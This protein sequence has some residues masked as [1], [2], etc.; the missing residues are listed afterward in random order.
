MSLK[1]I[2]KSALSGDTLILRGRPGPQGQP[3][4]ERVLHL[5]GI[6]APRLGNAER[7]DEAYAFESRDFLR[8]LT[9]GKEVTFVS[10][11]SLPS[12]DGTVRDIGSAS[13]GDLD[14]INEILK[15]GW[16]KVKESKREDNDVDIARKDLEDQARSSGKG[17]WA[18]PNHPPRQVYYTMPPDSQAFLNTW[19]GKPIDALVETVKDGSTLRVRL[20]LPDDVHQIINLSLAGVRSPRASGREGEAAEPWGDEARFFTESRIG[21]RM[22]RIVLLAVPAPTGVPFSAAGGSAPT[23]AS[24]MIGIVQHPAGNIAEFL[25]A[26]GLAR[27]VDW[28]AGMLSA[29]G[30]MERLRAAEKAGKEKRVGVYANVAPTA[31]PTAAANGSHDST[32]FEAQVV[33]VWSGDQISVMEK[34]SNKERRLQLSSVRA[35]RYVHLEL[36]NA[37]TA[38][39]ANDSKEFLRKKLIGKTVRVKIDFIRPAEGEFEERECATVRFGGANTNIAEQLIEKGYAT[40]LRHKRDDENRSPDYDKL[41]TA[42]QA[43]VADARGMHSGKTIT[44]PRIGNASESAAKAA[45]FLNSFKRQGKMPA[46]VMN[47]SSGSRFKMLIPKENQTLTFVLAGIRAPRAARMDRG[48]VIEKAEPFGQEAYDFALRRYMQRDVELDFDSTDKSGGFIGAMYLNNRAD[49]AAVD[50]VREGLASVHSYSADTLS[51]SKYLYDAEAEAKAAGRGMWEGYTEE[52]P[53]AEQPTDSSQDPEY[54]DILISDCRTTPEFGFSVQLLTNDG[55]ASLEKLMRDFSLHHRT[56]PTTAGFTPRNGELVSARFSGDGSWYRAK[57]K[58]ASA[59]KKEAEL[60]FI[61][62]GNYETVA[63]SHIRP[64]DPKFRS[65]PGQAHE[66]RLSFVSV[67]GKSSEYHDEAVDRFRSLCMDRKLIAIVDHREG[68]LM[69]LRLVDPADPST[70]SDRLSSINVDLVREG[71]AVVERKV[72][73][74]A[75]HPDITKRLQ[76]ASAEAKRDRAGIYEFGDVSPDDD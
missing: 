41:T 14:L 37:E 56:A 66:A 1:A 10:N 16:A 57:V 63:F 31:A 28:H 50:L 68:S 75:A 74:A 15:A 43:A 38:S 35:P 18:D 20:M 11:H 62:Y 65:L 12:T 21:Q 47:V 30:G 36:A 17:L 73:Y 13:I 76:E 45:Q 61:D 29:S 55:V 44:P 60:V 72:K 4:K 5:G 67:I 59:A 58:R 2:V 69:H 22:V 32:S 6:T 51:F 64:L 46:Q 19:K 54:M 26:G 9:V 70:G 52:A 40:A 7:D 27:V 39:W 33:R 71:F 48:N 8:S 53:E 23:S 24:I 49:N 3:P 25:V 42:E 34:G